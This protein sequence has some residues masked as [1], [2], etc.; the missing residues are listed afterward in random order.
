MLI[1]SNSAPYGAVF[2]SIICHLLYWRNSIPLSRTAALLLEPFLEPAD[3][4][5]HAGHVRIDFQGAPEPAKRLLVLL[6]GNVD[7][8]GAG[9][10]AEVARVAL[11]HLRTVGERLAVLPGQ[12]V[13]GGALVP[14]FGEV[15]LARNDARE[16]LDGRGVP[17]GL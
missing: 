15:G 17:A 14:A 12:V 5:L 9:K 16:E 8:A 6:Q 1:R 3:V 11:D 13:R 7:H 10:R 2:R 4:E